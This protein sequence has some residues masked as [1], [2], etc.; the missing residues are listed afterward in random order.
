[1][2]KVKMLLV[3]VGATGILLMAYAGMKVASVNQS[4][5]PDQSADQNSPA[6]QGSGNTYYV[7]LDG[8]NL[9]D[10]LTPETAF[11]TIAHGVSVLYAGDTL[12]LM[13]GNYG[14]EEIFLNRSGTEGDPITIKADVPGEAVMTGNG[15]GRAISTYGESYL[16]FEGIKITNYSSGIHLR[17]S[18]H[19][20]IRKCIFLSNNANGIS[21]SDGSPHDCPFSHHHLF[22]ENQFLDPYNKQDYGLCLYFS[23]NVEVLNNYFW[24]QHHQA[25]SFKEIMVDCR[26]A[27]NVFDGFLYSAIY[28]GQNDDI[29][30]GYPAR[31]SNL[32]AENNVFRPA[33]GYRAKRAI[34]IA[35]VSNAIVRNNFI[36]SNYGDHTSLQIAAN[37]TGSKVYGNVII[38]VTGEWAIEAAT[39]DTEIYNNTISG[40]DI[41]IAIVTGA[42]PVIRN[43]IFCNNT[44]QVKMRPTPYY[45]GTEEH[46]SYFNPDAEHLWVWQPDFENDPVLEH[47]DWFP[48]YSGKGATDITADPEFVGPIEPIELGGLNPR[49]V[50]DFTRADAYR[51]TGDSPCIDEGM[52]VGLPFLG[53]APDIGAFEY[54]PPPAG[55][56]VFYNNSAFDG[57]DPAA[58]AADDAA[59]ATDK[60]AMLPGETATFANYTG[61][62]RGINGIMVDIVDLPGVPTADDF[63]FKVGSPPVT[64]TILDVDFNSG[65][66]SFYYRDNTFRGTSQSSYASGR[67]NSSEG[68]SGGG[69]LQVDVGNV[70]SSD[71]TD[72]M[73]G[74]WRKVFSLSDAA[75]MRVT[76]RFKLTQTA[77]YEADEYSEALVSVD[78]QLFGTDGKE[79]MA[80]ISGDGDGGNP[81]S[82]GWR[83]VE[84]ELGTLSAGSHTL[85]VGAYNNKKT[86]N[87]ES[88][89]MLIDDVKIISGA[90]LPDDWTA[91]PAPTSITVR[92]GAGTDGSDRITIIWADNAIQKQWLQVTVKATDAMGLI[93][94]DVFYFGNAIGE[95]GNSSTD[96]K[97]TPTD[98]INTRN[99]P[100][101]L[102]GPDGP[103]GI[104]DAYDFNRDK[105]VGPS[106]EIIARN[107][108]T[109]ASTAI[110][111]ITTP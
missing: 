71:I 57:N 84:L 63:T 44:Q 87:N 85:L 95:T 92:S 41:G 30:V 40:C 74:G 34:C 5:N 101:T 73:S 98:Q 28:L 47:N 32:I 64:E 110:K 103:A 36:D 75:R 109:N 100:H 53:D 81:I 91:A 11:R 78:G 1:M 14:A 72:G 106:D 60:S 21:C 55:R 61:Y 2:N 50:P 7:S 12:I 56:Y 99:N 23:S 67:W 6:E 51:L 17:R 18:H 35:N 80:R 68:Y 10:G 108:G 4:R 43:N 96:A 27:G 25:C 49:F 22:T 13:S 26:V 45:N 102:G 48:D 20:I 38:N 107:N 93:R 70:D 104:D 29:A 105:K 69:A 111:L 79:Y 94:D 9:W 83:Y 54:A 65:T 82:T 59:I 88:T 3:S 37:S 31:S 86:S 33:E 58:G 52:D 89:K 46:S 19:T 76:L 97:V 77:N 66:N 39:S 8:D 42:N 24:G 16:V 90:S 62:S 15:S